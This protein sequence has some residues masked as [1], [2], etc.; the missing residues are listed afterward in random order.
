MM[1]ARFDYGAAGWSLV[2]RILDENSRRLSRTRRGTSDTGSSALKRPLRLSGEPLRVRAEKNE[3]LVHEFI[4]AAR[5]AR[6]KSGSSVRALL[7]AI[8]DLTN[9]GLVPD[10]RFRTWSIGAHQPSASGGAAVSG[11]EAKIE[12][13]DIPAAIDRFSATIHERWNELSVDPIPL[14]AWAEWQL[15]GGALHPFYDGCGRIA[16]SFGAALLIRGSSLLP[17]YDAPAEYFSRGNLGEAA[18]AG[19]V[20]ERIDACA[21]WLAAP[22][23]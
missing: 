16:R 17:L 19:Y 8:A 3:H 10:G 15:N 22:P 2:S 9:D 6:P 20:S 23:A 21:A 14:A 12:P 18:F 1:T 7:F 5:R 4:F 13:A 11:P